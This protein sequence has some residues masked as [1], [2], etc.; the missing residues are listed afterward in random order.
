[1]LSVDDNENSQKQSLDLIS[2]ITTM[3]MQ[4]TFF[5]H[6][7]A[8]VLHDY[9]EKLPETSWLYVLCAHFHFFWLP[10]IFTLV[11]ASLS[12]FSPLL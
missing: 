7:F 6:F 8:V 11:A 12:F 3:H 2:K 1:M 5:V 4:H 9:H 10:L